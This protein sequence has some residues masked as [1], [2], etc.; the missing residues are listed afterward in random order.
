M[1]QLKSLAVALLF[2]WTSNSFAVPNQIYFKTG[3][4]KGMY[5]GP[6][7]VGFTVIPTMEAEMEFFFSS[8]KSEIVKLVNAYDLS[9]AKNNY[10]YIGYGNR[11][12]L[13]GPAINFSAQ[14]FGVDYKSGVGMR[15]YV[16]WDAGIAHVLVLGATSSLDTTSA[17]FQLGITGGLIYQ[18]SQ[19]LGLDISLG[20]T[21]GFGFTTVSVGGLSLRGMFGVTYFL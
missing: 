21:Y 15:Y 4:L 17:L 1:L 19:S 2:L 8:A 16:G 12:Y 20:S 7:S 11:Y 14:E 3:M 5:S 18:I 10:T 13:G 6:R 9:E